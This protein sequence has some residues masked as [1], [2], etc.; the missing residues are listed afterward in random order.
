MSEENTRRGPFQF[1]FDNSA[2]LITG[3]I[4]ALVWA[5]FDKTAYEDFINADLLEWLGISDGHHDAPGGGAA[6]V[7]TASRCTSLSMTS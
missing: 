7:I 6:R 1:L 3:A 5:N 4:A 2:F